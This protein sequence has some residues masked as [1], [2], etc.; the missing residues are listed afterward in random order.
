MSKGHILIIDDEDQLRKLLSRLLALEGYTMHEAPN[1]RA[2]QKLLE[3]EEIRV[4]LSDVKL[5]DG[6]GVELVQ[7]I[8]TR[9]PE[10]ET[11]VLTAYGNIA[12]GV[13]AIKNGAFDYITK[14]DDNNRILPLVSKAMD[15]AV[16]QF[17]IRDLEKKIG[18]KY[19]FGNILGTSPEIKAAISLAEKVAPADITVLLLGETG[20]GKEVFAQ[21]IHQG[22]N[23]RQQPFVAVNCSAF[24]KEILESELFG[25]T[26]GAFTGAMKDKKGFFEEARGGTIFL[27]EIGEMAIELQA[28]ILRVLETQE[29]YKV[30][31]SKP[32]KTDVR[33]IAATNRNLEQEITAG[34]FRADLFYRLSAF[35]I[36]LPSLNERKK[37]IPLLADW[38]MQQ[39]A[40]KMNKR[41]TGMTPA[42]LQALQQHSWKGNIRELRNII[43]RA[44]ILTDTDTLDTAALPFDFQQGL[45]DDNP[46]SLRLADMEKRHIIRVLAHVKGNKTKAAELMDIGLTTLYNKIKEYN[47]TAL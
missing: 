11:I 22:S 24:G 2:A 18:G 31:E 39:V 20:A 45:S 47:I 41:I 43:E 30:G 6:N 13:Q 21:A 40:P 14:G 37:D 25:H 5:P 3:K 29:F 10:I 34:H 17:R 36:S 15:K 26:A 42:F 33:I 16:L 35:Q 4:V 44:V 23:R 19:N 12:D 32:T 1:V 27:D 28:K 7:T 38:F 46:A 9:Y 8:R